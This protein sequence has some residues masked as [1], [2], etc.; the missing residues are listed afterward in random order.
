MPRTQPALEDVTL[1][2]RAIPPGQFVISV[3][4]A[5]NRIPPV[6]KNLGLTRQ[7]LDA[8]IAWPDDRPGGDQPCSHNGGRACA[9]RPSGAQRGQGHH[10]GEPGKQ[11]GHPATG[12]STARPLQA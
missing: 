2:E 5:S 1:P 3:E 4:H 7:Q 8:H 12:A 11:C 9:G 10:H 6:Y